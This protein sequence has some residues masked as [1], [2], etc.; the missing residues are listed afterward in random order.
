[1][2][3]EDVK[4]VKK[5]PKTTGSFKSKRFESIIMLIFG[6]PC[7][8]EISQILFDV[9]DQ[10]AVHIFRMRSLNLVHCGSIVVVARS[11]RQNP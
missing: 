4:N 10:T 3:Q 9:E 2:L 1:M 11:Y 5:L 8:I 7:S 6:F